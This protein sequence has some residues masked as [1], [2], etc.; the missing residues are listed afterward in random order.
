MKTKTSISLQEWAQEKPLPAWMIN[1]PVFKGITQI[2]KVFPNIGLPNSSEPCDIKGNFAIDEAGKLLATI[3]SEIRAPL[4]AFVNGGYIEQV[5]LI[6]RFD[7]IFHEEKNRFI[8]YSKDEIVLKLPEAI[9]INGVVKFVKGTPLFDV[10]YACYQEFQ[11]F[12]WMMPQ[13]EK[14]P[15]WK[16]FNTNNVSSD[17]SSIVFASTGVDG[18]WDIATMSMRGISSCIRWDGKFKLTLIGSIADPFTGIIYLTSGK[19]H[20]KFGTRMIKRCVVRFV[21]NSE[22]E[23]PYL[24][25]DRMYPSLSQNVLEA[26]TDFLHSKSGLD[27]C[28]GPF[29]PQRTINNSYI[30]RNPINDKLTEKTLTYRDTKIPIGKVQSK[31][32]ER[33]DINAKVK[34]HNLTFR[35]KQ[36]TP[37]TSC[38]AAAENTPVAR[39]LR[40]A[41]FQYLIGEYAT[42]L[43]AN[44]VKRCPLQPDQSSADHIKQIAYMFFTDKKAITKV[45]NDKFLRGLRKYYA[46]NPDAKAALTMTAMKPV[47]TFISDAVKKTMK[48]E[49]ISIIKPTPVAKTKKQK[50]K[51]EAK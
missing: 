10:Y 51:S 32:S 4:E 34:E 36:A 1:H 39:W 42:S 47:F 16:D 50:L 28:F 33:K 46:P 27:V 9:T 48:A 6:E 11:R 38:I 3:A 18:L 24:L 8:T 12:A 25:V 41:D 14:L 15:G 43:V 37:L 21:V 17:S 45:E 44:L 49:L 23:K 30:P 35:L 29:I 7:D 5:A 31:V 20:G 19:K 22:K 13:L 2:D 26:F 40:T